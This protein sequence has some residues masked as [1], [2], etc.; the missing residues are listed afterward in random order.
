M[1][2]DAPID[3]LGYLPLTGKKPKEL[4]PCCMD[5]VWTGE[6]IAIWTPNGVNGRFLASPYRLKV[7]VHIMPLMFLKR[8]STLVACASQCARLSRRTSGRARFLRAL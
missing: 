7:L 4:F 2:W 3:P 5:A 8:L 6:G 1:D